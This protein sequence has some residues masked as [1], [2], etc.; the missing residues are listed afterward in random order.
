MQTDSL[1]IGSA[2]IAAAPVI[3]AHVCLLDEYKYVLFA[4]FASFVSTILLVLCSL[5][6][7]FTNNVWYMLL[8]SVPLDCA[9]KALLRWL[10]FKQTKVVISSRAQMSLGL[11]L[12][13]GF[14]L[15]HVLTMY[16]PMVFD[17][18]Y[19]VDFDDDHPA[20]FPNC[21]DFALMHNYMSIFQMA[22]GL[23]WFRFP[24]VNV[25]LMFI[26]TLVLQFGAAA[27]SMI[28]NLIGKQIAMVG[29]CYACFA[30]VVMSF[31]CSKYEPVRVAKE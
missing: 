17:Q 19:S 22:I 2:L 8:Y 6:S 24:R 31:G 18:A 12:G 5:C 13:S 3:G 4:W 16:V 20:F 25:F 21:I 23:L 14:A 27:M 9:G 10:T 15:A 7:L 30:A 11:G 29:V 26:L 1:N 28:P